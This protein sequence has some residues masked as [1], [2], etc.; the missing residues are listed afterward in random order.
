MG[1]IA[2]V[3][4]GAA[5]LLA[6]VAVLEK[7]CSPV[8]FEKNS[9]VGIK[10]MITGKGRCNL[11]NVAEPKDFIKNFPGNGSFLYSAL[12]N[13]DNNRL[14][15]FFASIGLPTKVERGG[16]IFPESDKAKDVVEVLLKYITKKGA[17]IYK[18]SPV[19]RLCV[20]N[21]KLIGLIA[22]DKKY[23]FNAAIISTGGLSYPR[24]GSTGDGYKLVKELGHT[25]VE[26]YPSL[27]P[28]DVKEKWVSEAAGL[29]LKNVEVKVYHKDKKIGQEFGEMLFT[30]TGVS[31][32]IIL[33]LSRTI[34][35]TLKKN[36]GPIKISINLK[37]AL[38]YQQLDMRFQRIFEENSNKQ[39]KNILDKVLPKSLIKPILS[40]SGINPQKP[41]NQ[42]SK[43]ERSQLIKLLQ[44]LELTV[45][46][47]RGF[48][49]AIVTGGGINVKEVDPS[50]MQS[51]LIKGLF[52][53]GEVLDIDGY[54][55]GYN[56]QAAF[57][58]GY[59]AGQSA[60]EYTLNLMHN[61]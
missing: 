5:G 61:I 52:L 4:G 51:K 36:G 15:D 47:Y 1:N 23:K 11:S 42:I 22:K 53:A 46:R 40:L 8:I 34:V 58:T 38:S 44:N 45:S 56:L 2:I 57:S 48:E 20:E 7:G 18:N 59:L 50:T 32:P 16:R 25:I 26:P 17:V 29:T 30:H 3:G 39:F 21:D 54:T 24:T 14:R 43:I 19:E 60:S 6:A 49:E 27:V 31:G 10:I 9:K 35:R 55:G 13:F 28:L 37:P 33:T 12:Y 41:I